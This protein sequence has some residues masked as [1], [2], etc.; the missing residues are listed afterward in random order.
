MKPHANGLCLFFFIKNTKPADAAPCSRGQPGCHGCGEAHAVS[1][2]GSALLPRS[3][4]RLHLPVAAGAF[5][6]R[7]LVDLKNQNKT[8]IC[9]KIVERFPQRVPFAP[10]HLGGPFLP[11]INLLL[12]SWS[13]LGRNEVA[14]LPL[15]HSA[16]DRRPLPGLVKLLYAPH[17]LF[18]VKSFSKRLRNKCMHSLRRCSNRDT[19]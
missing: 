10:F 9:A 5:P 14:D 12:P 4:N 8:V 19:S 7:R 18:S 17:K 6:E 11:Q 15:L 3:P 16:W 13:L 1:P 2:G